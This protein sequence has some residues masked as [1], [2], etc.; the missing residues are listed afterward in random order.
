MWCFEC[1]YAKHRSITTLIQ[2]SIVVWT[3]L[4][5]CIGTSGIT[6]PGVIL[7]RR[8]ENNTLWWQP[9]YSL[10]TINMG[11][12]GANDSSSIVRSYQYNSMS[13]TGTQYTPFN[14]S[15]AI[16]HANDMNSTLFIIIWTEF[17]WTI[18]P[19]IVTHVSYLK[20]LWFYSNIRWIDQE[21][22]QVPTFP[23]VLDCFYHKISIFEIAQAE[24]LIC[25]LS[26]IL[27][28]DIIQ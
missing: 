25:Y 9:Y 6:F 10:F 15:W 13:M 12:I 5:Y 21:L 4:W 2:C 23:L 17:I 20:R 22:I 7:K 28:M 24:T 11:S 18:T 16:Q 8:P 14:M 1:L 19:K 26:Y 27:Q 3:L